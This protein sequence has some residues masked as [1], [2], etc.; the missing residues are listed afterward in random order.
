MLKVSKL[1]AYEAYHSRM[2]IYIHDAYTCQSIDSQVLQITRLSVPLQCDV[3]DWILYNSNATL[4]FT[5][6]FRY[7]Q[8]KSYLF[9]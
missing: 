4:A 2:Y 8:M 5:Q 3:K 9:R 7:A 6:L 1:P